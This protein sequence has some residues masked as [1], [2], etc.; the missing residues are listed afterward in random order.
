[1]P[2]PGAP[3]LAL[4]RPGG[5]PA[6]IAKVHHPRTRTS[7]D[8]R[9]E[10]G[11]GRRAAPDRRRGPAALAAPRI[12]VAP[13]EADQALTGQ[14]AFLIL[15]Q[16]AGCGRVRPGAAGCERPD[17]EGTW[18]GRCAPWLVFVAVVF[19]PRLQPPYWAW[20]AWSQPRREQR[21]PGP[22][23]SRPSTTSGSPPRPSLDQAT[24]T[25]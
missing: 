10:C 8:A 19:L 3:E 13:G 24:S 25:G 11:M 5:R 20:G 17:R 16:P 9:V 12:S 6:A 23:W 18:A 22:P 1:M 21:P 7:R 14:R 15:S 4:R 2:A